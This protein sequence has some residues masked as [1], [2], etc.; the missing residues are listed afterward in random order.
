MDL[1]KLH[2]TD[3]IYASLPLASHF[4]SAFP[5]CPPSPSIHY[6]FHFHHFCPSLFIRPQRTKF[7]ISSQWRL[8][9]RGG[10][11]SLAVKALEI[12]TPE[13]EEEGS[14]SAAAAAGV[15]C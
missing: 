6:P 13:E 4:R 12:T 10:A 3:H 1:V 7:L 15:L 5:S 9:M 14:L 2:V 11:K 8:A